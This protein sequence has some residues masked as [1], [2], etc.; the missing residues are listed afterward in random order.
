MARQ[1][2]RCVVAVVSK[3]PQPWPTEASPAERL[4]A[5]VN[6]AGGPEWELLEPGK[7]R[8]P[9]L[10]T[11]RANL[12]VV[13]LPEEGPTLFSDLTAIEPAAGETQQ[14]E[15]QLLPGCRLEGKLAE[16]VPRPVFGGYVIARVGAPLKNVWTDWAEVAE[17]GTFVFESLPRDKDEVVQ[18]VGLCEG[19]ASTSHGGFEPGASRATPQ[20]ARLGEPVVHHTLEMIPTA[21][22]ILQ[23][24][25]FNGKPLPDVE[26]AFNPNVKWL[27]GGSSI[28][29]HPKLSSRDQLLSKVT[30]DWQDWQRNYPHAAKSDA[31]GIATFLNL[32]PYGPFTF[33]ALHDDFEMQI[34]EDHQ[35][36]RLGTIELEPDVFSEA[37][38]VMQPKGM[39]KITG[40]VKREP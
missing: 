13:C 3:S 38:F 25:D 36:S 35:E 11:A 23:F 5:V 12:R 4:F 18:L 17:D 22:C 1:R 7:L 40:K 19:Y 34:V 20:K 15:V 8:S 10:P 14:V 39:D 29:A 32:P 2:L 24:R 28:F 33:E 37:E 9:M 6:Y 31:N 21:K 30:F 16:N 26:A 27:S